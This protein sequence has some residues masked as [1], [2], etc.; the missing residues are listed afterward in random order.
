MSRSPPAP[1]HA[2]PRGRRRP[3]LLLVAIGV[4]VALLLAAATVVVLARRG[5]GRPAAT[6]ARATDT[7]FTPSAPPTGPTGAAA[8]VGQ[9][10][11]YADGLQVTLTGV[12]LAT[13]KGDFGT[14][15]GTPLLVVSLRVFNGTG[16]RLRGPEFLVRARAGST[17][18]TADDSI[19]G[20]LGDADTLS[21]AAG[22]TRVEP[23]GQAAYGALDP[24]KAI[25]GKYAFELKRRADAASV[26]V[27]VAPVYDSGDLAPPAAVFSAA[28]P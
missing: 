25:A 23:Q 27:E 10:V 11:V 4:I 7:G 18:Y 28:L 26:A 5:H 17:Q 16:T 9:P 21:S 1:A 20:A 13:A 19:D 24:S 22:L 8:R 12:G 6:V 2:A 14:K 3:V 15:Q